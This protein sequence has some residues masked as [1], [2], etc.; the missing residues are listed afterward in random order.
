ML[1]NVYSKKYFF[2]FF[3]MAYLE[4]MFI[5]L[6]RFELR[7]D[8]VIGK[9]AQATCYV[10]IEKNNPQQVLCAKI[11]SKAIKES[12]DQ[13]RLLREVIILKSLKHN[14]ILSF[15]GFNLY[16]FD[17]RPQPTI[18]TEYMR[19]GSLE[20]LLTKVRS[21]KTPTNWNETKKYIC[22]VGI[23]AAMR[24]LHR[25]NIIHLD[26]KPANVLL[27]DNLY[28][29]VCDFGLSRAYLHNLGLKV[30]QK[31]G[32]LLYKAPETFRGCNRTEKVDI[33]S[34]AILSY[35]VSTGLMPYGPCKP[36]DISMNRL[37]SAQ[38][39]P[40]FKNDCNVNPK[41]QE[42]IKQ[43][44]SENPNDRPSFDYIYDSLV[45]DSSMLINDQIDR[46]ELRSYIGNIQDNCK[47]D[48]RVKLDF[49]Q[50][51]SQ[52]DDRPS[53]PN[54]IIPTDEKY[55]INMLNDFV[56]N[57]F[58]GDIDIQITLYLKMLGFIST[59]KDPKNFARIT[60]FANRL[61]QEG[62]QKALLFLKNAFGEIIAEG[63]KTFSKSDIINTNATCLN[64]SPTVEIIQEEAFSDLKNLNFIN[65]PPNIK[66]IGQNAF[67][68]CKNLVWVNLNNKITEIPQGAFENCN[69]L[70]YIEFPSSSLT[71]IK[72]AAFRKCTSLDQILI[73]DSVATIEKNAFNGCKNLI[74]VHMSSAT[75][76][77]INSSN[78]YGFTLSPFPLRTQIIK[79]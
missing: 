69:N 32:T 16:D 1:L 76:Y 19:N 63:K 35:E 66:T 52:Y 18:I 28:P 64:I 21:G 5:D 6:N 78:E 71:T 72:E 8:K 12:S 60:I 39:R 2:H 48:G 70:K 46:A 53:N 40:E 56:Q 38:A 22:I 15:K 37:I 74:V 11:S 79:H 33:Y 29:K 43:C 65:L 31:E 10:V 34:F 45:D 47:K 26:L 25:S 9:G 36:N 41:F 27:D 68:G 73:P 4:G 17:R 54:D 7:K 50:P 24:Y 61:A 75:K 59:C 58:I 49:S 20:D 42:L 3:K 44:W 77:G 57:G 30:A 23:A 14:S 62:N 13:E 55:R 67:K 51:E